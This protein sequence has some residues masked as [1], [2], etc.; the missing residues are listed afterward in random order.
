MPSSLPIQAGRASATAASRRGHAVDGKCQDLGT[1]R[2]FFADHG[3]LTA[4][5]HFAYARSLL[6]YGHQ[7]AAQAHVREG[8]TEAFGRM[9]KTMLA[10]VS[11]I[12][13]PRGR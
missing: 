4:K 10:A 5:G 11:A 1:V 2:A 6:A 13:H 3:P 9:S 8:W 7:A 12:D